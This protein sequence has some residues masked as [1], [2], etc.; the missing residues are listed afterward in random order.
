M[1]WRSTRAVNLQRLE[2]HRFCIG[3][4]KIHFAAPEIGRTQLRALNAIQR[5][6]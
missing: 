6:V 5:A 3:A 1:V 2:K 4:L